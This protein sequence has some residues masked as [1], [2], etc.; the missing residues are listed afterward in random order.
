[1]VFTPY[2]VS[3]LTGERVSVSVLPATQ[4]DLDATA[5]EPKWQT[6]WNAAYLADASVERFAVKVPDGELIGLGAYQIRGNKAYVYIVYAESAPHSNPTMKPREDRK[7]YGIGALLLAFGIKYSIDH[8]CRGD[9][10]FEAK[11]DRLAEHYEKDF[12]AIRIPSEQP[13][14]PKRY[15]LVDEVAWAVFSRF[16]EEGA[17]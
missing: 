10:V 15:M 4:D 14:G 3:S 16:L 5:R 8:G 17:E 6:A 1:M 11:T 7:Y 12:H 9:I 13:G 2:V